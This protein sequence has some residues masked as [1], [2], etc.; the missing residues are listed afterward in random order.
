[1]T[2]LT[3]SITSY[4]EGYLHKCFGG[5]LQIASASVKWSSL[6]NIIPLVSMGVITIMD[7][8][9]FPLQVSSYMMHNHKL[10]LSLP[11]TMYIFNL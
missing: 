2:G 6:I 8:M 11:L 5:L 3:N 10:A 9:G 1:M 7:G 4:P